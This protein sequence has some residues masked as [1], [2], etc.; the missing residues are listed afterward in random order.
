ML[1]TLRNRLIASH[2]LPLL[3]IVPLMGIVLVYVLETQVLLPL[4]ADDLTE[5]AAL[6]VEI[7][8]NY[9][10]TWD[11]PTQAQVIVEQ[12]SPTLSA[13]LML[14]NPEGQLLASSDPNDADRLNQ[15]IEA[16]G[17]VTAT[18]G[19]NSAIT[20]Y[21]QRLHAEVV[22]ILIPVLGPDHH[23]VGIVRLT[24]QLTGVYQQLLRLRSVVIGVL[25]LGLVLG[26]IVGLVLALN[27]QRPL[28][29]VTQA[30]SQ[31]SS[32]QLLA[33]LPEQ[34]PEELRTL[35]QAFNALTERL[36]SLEA[37]RRQLLANLVH[38]LGRPLGAL[39]SAIQA[40]TGGADQDEALR[41]ELLVGM[42]AEVQRLQRL[43]NDLAQLHEQVLGTLELNRQP[44]VL[45][46]WL[47]R[48][49][50]PWREA[51]QKK[52][53][54]WQ[55]EIPTNLPQVD[56][57]PDRLT[58]VIGNLISN[59]VKYT[60]RGQ[61]SVSVGVKENE[62]WIQVSDTGPGIAPEEQAKIFEPFYRGRMSRRFPQGM[63]LGLTI[64]RDMVIA[65]G[66][67]L[68]LQSTPGLG[69]QFTLWLPLH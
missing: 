5:Q 58:Q 68:E 1:A 47:P 59:A 24:H 50:G 45:A 34:G 38:E 26:A 57:D 39:L 32:G 14:L 20:T 30:V 31:L 19:E 27:L 69:S 60:S 13:R 44:V 56:F 22:D 63:G 12:T 37:A 21:S 2:V 35:A 64:A 67:R 53:L 42:Q 51:A 7:T 8:R 28:Q 43:L 52:K 23:V 54:H 9:P 49:L 62:L 48:I 61:V 10:G 25:A 3:V 40:M 66:G 11:D 65:H 15:K 6:V 18:Q 36:R 4:L 33:V 16:A 41:K 46:E 17:L 55:A 29:H